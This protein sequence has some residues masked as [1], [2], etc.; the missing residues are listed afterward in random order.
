MFKLF[1]KWIILAF[2][3]VILTYFIPGIYV[4][5]I[6]T[7]FYAGLVIGLINVFIR[8]VFQLI[9]FPIT[10]LTLGLFSLIINALMFWLASA[11]VPG[12][13]VHGFL[14]ALLGSICLSIVYAFLSFWVPPLRET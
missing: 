13:V 12:F 10:F 7:A 5:N 1:L 8:P 4:K 3:L 14:S 2:S 9:A 11:W 6:Q